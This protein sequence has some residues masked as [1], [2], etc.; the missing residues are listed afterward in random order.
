M[1]SA[2]EDILPRCAH[3]ETLLRGVALESLWLGSQEGNG[4]GHARGRL[5]TVFGGTGFLDRRIVRQL[6]DHDL[7][8]RAASRHPE[9]ARAGSS[10]SVRLSGTTRSLVRCHP[11]RS[12]SM[13]PWAPGATACATSAP[14]CRC[15]LRGVRQSCLVHVRQGRGS[16]INGSNRAACTR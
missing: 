10:T 7:E 6:L 1:K 16:S 14:G 8:V 3:Y 12:I 4:S 11:A 15:H 2:L 13:T 9:G 5:V